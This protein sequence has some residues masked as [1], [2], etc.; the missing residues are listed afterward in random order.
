M[1]VNFLFGRTKK[2]HS[3]FS[4]AHA[5]AVGK[6]IPEEKCCESLGSSNKGEQISLTNELPTLEPMP[7]LWRW[8]ITKPLV[9]HIF[10][11][12]LFFSEVFCKPY[13]NGSRTYL[14]SL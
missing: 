4:N 7:H 3:M 10:S 13:R 9:L 11:R 5:L 14:L 6:S 2:G 8:G 12:N 1:A